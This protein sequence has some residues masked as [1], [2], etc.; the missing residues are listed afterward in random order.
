MRS[1]FFFRTALKAMT[2]RLPELAWTILAF[3]ITFSWFQFWFGET[4]VSTLAGAIVAGLASDFIPGFT[5]FMLN[6]F[7]Y[8]GTRKGKNILS[9]KVRESNILEEIES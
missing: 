9:D 1:Q 7:F 8:E 2:A 5:V 3:Y 6:D 4:D